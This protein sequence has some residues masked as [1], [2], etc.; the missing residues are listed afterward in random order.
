[1]ASLCSTLCKASLFTSC[2]LQVS[3]SL[4]PNA[5]TSLLKY[6]YTCNHYTSYKSAP[7]CHLTRVNLPLNALPADL[8]RSLQQAECQ[9][10]ARN[11][12]SLRANMACP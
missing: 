5:F 1:M 2:D 6:L 10:F 7:S 9:V 3:P 12:G 4:D 8:F 11:L